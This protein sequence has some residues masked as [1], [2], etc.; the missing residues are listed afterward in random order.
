[1]PSRHRC[2]TVNTS[3][4]E[5]RLSFLHIRV[6][7]PHAAK[8]QFKAMIS[9][10][11]VPGF[12]RL[13][14]NAPGSQFPAIVLPAKYSGRGCCEISHS[15]IRRTA[16]I[17][18]RPRVRS[19]TGLGL[20]LVALL[21]ESPLFALGVMN[22]GRQTRSEVSRGTAVIGQWQLGV[23]L[24]RRVERLVQVPLNNHRNAHPTSAASTA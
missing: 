7:L 11:P 10:D 6:S 23:A 12:D 15:R 16:R 13:P 14:P 8:G 1:M 17:V 3:L 22:D 18:R 9:C 24:G 2:T 20:R 5:P 19:A 4:L 21:P